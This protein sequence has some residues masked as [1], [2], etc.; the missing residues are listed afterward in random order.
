MPT[1]VVAVG[2]GERDGSGEA[3]HHDMDHLGDTDVAI[4]IFVGSKP[5]V[6]MHSYYQRGGAAYSLA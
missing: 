3:V 4:E 2:W 6:F 5:R 1:G